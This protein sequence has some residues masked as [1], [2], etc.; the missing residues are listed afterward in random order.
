MTLYARFGAIWL[1]AMHSKCGKVGV[2]RYVT[3][4]P[5]RSERSE[6]ITRS[7]PHVLRRSLRAFQNA[8]QNAPFM[9]GY[10]VS[11]QLTRSP[12]FS[13]PRDLGTLRS[14]S[15]LVP[16]LSDQSYAPGHRNQSI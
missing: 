4:F 14:P 15:E 10:E 8:F 11:M 5:D 12:P 13:S 16:H 2:E 1:R 6:K 3:G 7:I 9:S